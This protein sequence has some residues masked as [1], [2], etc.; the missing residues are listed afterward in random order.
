MQERYLAESA[1][2]LVYAID[3]KHE[4]LC[5]NIGF[6]EGAVL[7]KS[8]LEDRLK[9]NTAYRGQKYRTYFE[10]PNLH[11]SRWAT[12]TFIRTSEREKA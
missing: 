7:N 1:H 9:Q 12:L 10:I 3:M 5:Q 2:I 11:Y 6:M 4:V 8:P